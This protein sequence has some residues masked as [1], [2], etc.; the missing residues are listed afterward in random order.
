LH[1]KTRGLKMSFI[2]RRPLEAEV[3]IVDKQK[4]EWRYPVDL[5]N[6]TYTCRQ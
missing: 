3:T 4:R 2:K 5:S 6:R 1:E